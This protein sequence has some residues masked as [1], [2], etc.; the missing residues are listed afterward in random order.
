MKKAIRFFSVLSAV[1]LMLSASMA[2]LAAEMSGY[3]YTVTISAGNQG[4]LSTADGISISVE[5]GGDY[6]INLEDGGKLVR[7]TG[8][9]A[10]NH[11]RFLNSAASVA[12]DSKYYVKG[13]RMGGRDDSLNLAYFQVERDQDYVVA[14]GIRGNMVQY[15]VNY[16][17]A[18]GNRLY[19][20]QI[21]YG[22]VGDRPVIAYLYVEGYQPQAYNL[23]RTLQSDAGKNVF[24]FVYTPIATTAPGPAGGGAAGGAPGGEA[25]GDAAVPGAGAAPA[26][27]G[28]AA[29]GGDAGIA[30]VEDEVPPE[31]LDDDDMPL[32]GNETEP[33]EPED[34]IDLDE[35]DMPLANFESGNDG[36]VARA[37]GRLLKY[38]W[39]AV[40]IGL[41]AVIALVA[42]AYTYRK[43]K[44]AE[45][46]KSEKKD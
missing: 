16:E 42:G 21:Y 18:A 7:I 34:V 31:D 8:L 24:T 3:T 37:N 5:G 43:M 1:F 2:C 12:E 9:T 26:G 45:S 46:V 4:S 28:A 39:F 36:T 11:V 15:T 22:N 33:G 38:M 32:A 29:P 23:T 20:P 13:I 27:G 25:P 14:Y 44:K 19:P 17:D 6:A 10:A 35:E 41:V 30:P 40:G